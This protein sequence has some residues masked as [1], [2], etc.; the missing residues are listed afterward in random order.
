[1]W[2]AICSVMAF[3]LMG[4]EHGVR[5]IPAAP[6]N[7]VLTKTAEEESSLQRFGRVMLLLV[8]GNGLLGFSHISVVFLLSWF[9]ALCLGLYT[10]AFSYSF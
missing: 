9:R 2:V 1:M 5:A 6:Q 8:I 4:T 7:D 10:W 3:I